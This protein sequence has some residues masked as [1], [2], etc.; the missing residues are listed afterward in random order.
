MMSTHDKQGFPWA[1][2]S[3]LKP[4]DKVRVDAGFDCMGPNTVKVVHSNIRQGLWIG[5]QHGEHFLEPQADDGEH[6]V[7]LYHVR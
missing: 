1:K 7:G 4:G 3:E 5:C 2:L 6:C